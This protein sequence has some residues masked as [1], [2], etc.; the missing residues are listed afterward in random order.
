MSGE[1]INL[2]GAKGSEK[3]KTSYKWEILDVTGKAHKYTNHDLNSKTPFPI[4]NNSVS[5]YYASMILE[6]I[7]PVNLGFV[8]Q[9]VYR[10]LE[11]RGIIRIVVPDFSVA[12]QWF[13][14]SPEKL[15]NPHCPYNPPGY[16]QT[17]MG[18]LMS[19]VISSGPEG[20]ANGR[21]GHQNMFDF[22]TLTWWLVQAGF[23]PRNVRRTKFN[24][25]TEV[26][27][28]MDFERYRT[29]A[30]YVEAQK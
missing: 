4:A 25:C 29:W 8:L 1:L 16:P 9:E 7:H 21:T 11:P 24:V 15:F 12:I 17:L 22:E 23:A 3:L 19:W 18:R 27:D 6:H 28:G 13:I 14:N 5:A 2:G 26:F 10:T 20:K 30:L